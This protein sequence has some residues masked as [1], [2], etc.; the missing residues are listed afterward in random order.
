MLRTKRGFTLIELLVVIVII[1]ILVAIALPNFI[2]IKIKAKEAEVK[3]NLHAIQLA[4]ERYATDTGGQYPFF[5]YGGDVY[6]N[7]GV[8]L[9]YRTIDQSGPTQCKHPFDLFNA[10]LSESWAHTYSHSAVTGDAV[11]DNTI[12]TRGYEYG[13]SIAYEGYISSYPTNPFLS[14]KARTNHGEGSI[15]WAG[16]TV[17]R[18]CGGRDG[19]SMFNVGWAG[20][21]PY[22]IAYEGDGE[23]VDVI[24]F[25]FPGQFYYHPRFSDGACNADHFTAQYNS[26]GGFGGGNFVT[27]CGASARPALVWSHDVAGYDLLAYGDPK[28]EGLDIDYPGYSG[29]KTYGWRTGYLNNTNEPNPYNPSGRPGAPYFEGTYETHRVADGIPD[30]YIIHLSSIQDAKTEGVL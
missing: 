19:R 23:P 5:L 15:Q 22:Y 28:T 17:F 1:G 10:S 16:W 12:G 13:D 6:F 4:V 2:K 11:D 25:E 30:Y 29:S 7:V 20:E 3:Q 14:L 18:G 21:A 9:S 27:A 24:K 8:I 26:T